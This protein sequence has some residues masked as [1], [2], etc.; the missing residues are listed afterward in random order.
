ML[1]TL[2]SFVEQ[3]P[4][5]VLRRLYTL[6]AAGRE[7]G[8]QTDPLAQEHFTR[9]VEELLMD[10]RDLLVVDPNKSRGAP[11]LAYG[12]RRSRMAAIASAV[13]RVGRALPVSDSRR[14]AA[15]HVPPTARHADDYC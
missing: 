7:W 14:V 15:P 2:G 9:I 12:L 1:Q 5:G 10:H 13:V 8:Y 6:L 11:A 4:P 3:D